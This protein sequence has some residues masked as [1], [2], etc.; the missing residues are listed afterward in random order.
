MREALGSP[1]V[2]SRA[3]GGP[4][5]EDLVRL[6][7]PEIS[8]KVRDIDDADAILVLGTDPLHSSPILDL[9]IRKAIRRNGARLAVATE[10]P[11]ALDGGAEAVARYAPGGA[12]AFL[13]E[14]AAVLATAGA[15]SSLATRRSDAEG[16]SPE[17]QSSSRAKR[18]EGAPAV[19][20]MLRSAERVVVVWGER[21]GREQAPSRPCSTWR[22]H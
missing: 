14:L 20:D 6:S 16:L 17:A 2:E 13:A 11:T 8:A 1:H 12:G 3:A 10:R 19:A 9:R 21:I 15:P 22:R 7:Q 5:R 4:S 18:S